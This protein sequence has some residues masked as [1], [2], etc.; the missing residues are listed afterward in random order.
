MKNKR[1]ALLI[2]DCSIDNFVNNK[3]IRNYG[4]SDEVTE[5]LNPLKALDYLRSLTDVNQFPDF[6]FL[7]LNMPVMS[8]EEFLEEYHKLDGSIRKRCRLIILSGFVDS[9]LTP[10]FSSNPHVLAMMNKPLIKMNLDY[11]ESLITSTG[12]VNRLRNEFAN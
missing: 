12:I 3:M 1:T 7:D 4:F 6:I 8:G 9:G 11:L 2:D 5:F 10:V